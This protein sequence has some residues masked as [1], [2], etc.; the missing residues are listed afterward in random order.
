MYDGDL[1]LVIDNPLMMKGVDR[2]CAVVLDIEDKIT[3]AAEAYNKTNILKVIL[4]TMKSLI[5][6]TSNCAT[7]YHNKTAKSN[8]QKK[9]YG[10][11]VDLLSIINGKNIDYSKTGIMYNIPHKIAKYSKPLPYFMRY[12]SPYYKTLQKFSFSHSNM[13]RLAKEIERW[14]NSVIKNRKKNDAFDYHIMIDDSIPFDEDKLEKIIVIYHQYKKEI[15]ELKKEATYFANPQKYK[16]WFNANYPDL[17]QEQIKEFT[18]DWNYYYQK[19]KKLCEDICKDPK[20]LANICVYICYVL[21]PKQSSQFMWKV[22]SD[23]ILK[24]IQQQDLLLPK[25]SSKGTLLYLGKQ[26]E[27]CLLTAMEILNDK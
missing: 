7:A 14:E 22:S 8:E 13:N 6:E 20:E 26:Y 23:G 10:E 24:N 25:K 16:N 21:Y 4:R 18:F 9:I 3:A 2:E 1:C 11:Y 17:S 15:S 12:A 27:L 19:Y 5:G